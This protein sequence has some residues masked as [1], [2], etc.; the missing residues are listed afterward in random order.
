MHFTGGFPAKSML[1]K[2]SKGLITDIAALTTLSDN[3]QSAF[4]SV[5]RTWYIG[6]PRNGFSLYFSLI[7]SGFSLHFRLCSRDISVFQNFQNFI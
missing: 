5:V 3:L 1:K 2:E 4:G 7:F 6:T